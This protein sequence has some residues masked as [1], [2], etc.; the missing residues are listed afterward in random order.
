MDSRF[1]GNDE[2]GCFLTFYEFV[3]LKAED[4]A[5]QW[6]SKSLIVLKGGGDDYKLMGLMEWSLL[7]ALPIFP[8]G[9]RL[10][11]QHEL[12]RSMRLTE[13]I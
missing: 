4:K 11:E 6:V 2:N 12:A 8:A 7:F 3:N 13:S 10:N 5:L 9:V 1:R